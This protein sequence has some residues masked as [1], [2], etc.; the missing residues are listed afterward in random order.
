MLSIKKISPIILASLITAS[1]AT[2]GDPGSGVSKKVLD[3]VSYYNGIFDNQ[4]QTQQPGDNHALIQV[5]VVPV[6]IPCLRPNPVMF[7]EEAVNGIVRNF[8]L[9]EVTE[10]NED[11]VSL[12]VY[13]YDNQ[14]NYKPGEFKVENVSNMSCGELKRTEGCTASYRVAKGYVFGNYAHCSYTVSG[15]HPRF[16]G[17]HRC[18][19][20]TIEMPLDA[21][22][23]TPMEPYEFLYTEPK[24]PVLNAPEG[25]VA[26]C[27]P[28]S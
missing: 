21:E 4:N 6:D 2:A 24:F 10:G 8:L 12:V 3:F 18:D 23:P 14:T 26:P 5:R 11:T 20:V 27:G 9:A 1:L 19:S 16:T 28:K 17:L 22:Q 15:K 13:N 25:Y 7:G